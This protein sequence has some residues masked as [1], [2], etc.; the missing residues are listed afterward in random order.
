[1]K[2]NKSQ[3]SKNKLKQIQ[4]FWPFQTLNSSIFMISPYIMKLGNADD[5]IL[6]NKLNMLCT[7]Y[8]ILS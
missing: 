2:K 1:M 7:L 5:R 4:M 8:N 3:D 6:Y